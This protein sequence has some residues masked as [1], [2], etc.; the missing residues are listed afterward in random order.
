M[1][2][3]VVWEKPSQCDCTWWTKSNSRYVGNKVGCFVVFLRGANTI[4]RV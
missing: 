3:I 4:R 2:M 1:V